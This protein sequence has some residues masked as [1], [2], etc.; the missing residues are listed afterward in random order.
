MN[1][2]FSRTARRT[3]LHQK[4]AAR[5]RRRG[6]SALN[7]FPSTRA[8]QVLLYAGIQKTLD[9][10]Q[11]HSMEAC[12]RSVPADGLRVWF[13]TALPPFLAALSLC[14]C[15]EQDCE[16]MRSVPAE[17]ARINSKQPRTPTNSNPNYPSGRTKRP[18]LWVNQMNSGPSAVREKTLVFCCARLPSGVHWSSV[19]QAPFFHSTMS[20]PSSSLR[21]SPGR[22]PLIS[23]TTRMQAIPEKL[24]LAS[25]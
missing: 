10:I 11:L 22:I 3:R 4:T 5:G 17:R 23:S 16:R 20:E 15:T 25:A 8:S 9:Y 13:M 6:E 7:N 24:L 19:T 12:T 14:R 21:F 18:G 2:V 1:T